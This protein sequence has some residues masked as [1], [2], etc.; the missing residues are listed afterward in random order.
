M[1]H[2]TLF[3]A[4]GVSWA[5]SVCMFAV[6]WDNE[7][8]QC[9]SVKCYAPL[10]VSWNP[11]KNCNVFVCAKE[12]VQLYLGGQ[13]PTT[14]LISTNTDEEKHGNKACWLLYLNTSVS[15]PV[16]TYRSDTYIEFSIIS[17][18]QCWKKLG[19]SKI[20]GSIR[21]LWHLSNTVNWY[22]NDN[23]SNYQSYWMVKN[24]LDWVNL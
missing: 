6:A 16:R 9:H 12:T 14:C 3:Q 2:I 4:C 20:Y 8:P 10:P 24:K 11:C 23:V 1:V 17:Q 5:S 7:V 15:E 21:Y 22:M 19:G 18:I 13:K